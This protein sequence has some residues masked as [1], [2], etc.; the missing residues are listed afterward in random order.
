MR[1]IRLF[2]VN[3]TILCSR[4]FLEFSYTLCIGDF[5]CQFLLAFISTLR[6]CLLW[7]NC[8]AALLSYLQANSDI[9]EKL[10]RYYTIFKSF[11]FCDIFND[12]KIALL[13]FL[14][15]ICCNLLIQKFF[16]DFLRAET[17]R[18]RQ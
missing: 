17:N 1:N 8:L 6:F 5:G 14:G 3:N 13:F 9:Y 18:F 15:F 16:L 4:D 11:I 12:H 7:S 10:Q 2:Q